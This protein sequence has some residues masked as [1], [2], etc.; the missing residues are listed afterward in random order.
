MSVSRRDGAFDQHA[1]QLWERDAGLRERVA[2]S[3]SAAHGAWGGF[4][5]ISGG[6]GAIL[7]TIRGKQAKGFED[8][9]I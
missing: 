9:E 2:G 5:P 8:S 6:D 4:A 3:P 7:V 1:G